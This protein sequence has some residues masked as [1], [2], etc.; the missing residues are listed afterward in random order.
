MRRNAWTTGTRRGMEPQVNEDA[1][2]DDDNTGED[3]KPDR[4]PAEFA[5]EREHILLKLHVVCVAD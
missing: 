1:R 4:T 5:G 3:D 2:Q